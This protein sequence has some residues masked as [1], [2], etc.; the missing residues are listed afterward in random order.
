MPKRYLPCLYCSCASIHECTRTNHAGRSWKAQED[1]KALCGNYNQRTERELYKTAYNRCAN[2]RDRS[3]TG[4]TDRPL[5][6]P[7]LIVLILDCR[8]HDFLILNPLGSWFA[9][10]VLFFF[11][12][13]KPSDRSPLSLSFNNLCKSW[14]ILGSAS[15]WKDLCTPSCWLLCCVSPRV[16]VRC[17]KYRVH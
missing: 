10:G 12:L 14:T 6:L 3:T 15:G 5:P 8:E 11:S 1:A 17:V 9:F 16:S 13:L 4:A 2:D 7:T